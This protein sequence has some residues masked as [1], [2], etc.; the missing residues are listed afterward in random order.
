MGES[1]AL[2]A[3][4]LFASSHVTVKR[5]LRSTSII[6]AVLV[7]LLGAW[8]VVGIVVIARPPTTIRLH[9]V[10]LFLLAGI[11]A[12]GMARWAAMSGVMHLGPSTAIPIQQAVRP[13]LAVGGAILLLGESPSLLAIV[14]IAAIVVGACY[15]SLSIAPEPL[16]LKHSR[17]WRLSYPFLAGV[18]YA[19]ADLFAKEAV[20]TLSEP[21][22]GAFLSTSAALVIW[23][24]AALVSRNLRQSIVLG[25][26]PWWM[27]LSGAMAGLALV[28]LFMA[29]ELAPVSIVTP[30]ASA[31]PFAVFLLSWVFLRDVETVTRPMVVAGACVMGGTV[32]VAM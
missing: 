5:Y 19:V 6:A 1:L 30:I 10:V 9:G 26:G 7:S 3:T 23:G 28:T 24:G 2:M 14:G 25:E 18:S 16:D 11:A 15:L 27:L 4:F 13:L 20:S 12:P 32:I 22:F 17:R 31:Q 29:L 21:L 8:L